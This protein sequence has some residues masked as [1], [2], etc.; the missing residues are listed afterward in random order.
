MA[1]HLNLFKSAVS[2]ATL[3]LASG[4]TTISQAEMLTDPT[5]P[6][7]VLGV[8]GADTSVASG[9]VLQSV[10][11]SP[12]RRVAVISGHTVRVG[13]KVEG[14]TVVRIMDGAVALQDG[15]TVKIL[16]LFPGIDKHLMRR[17]P[18]AKSNVARNKAK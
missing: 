11:I 5:R 1:E 18:A 3:L 17:T 9:P 13:D 15:K 4:V 7:V 10:L 6:P 12:M 2:I 14:M 8:R 16:K